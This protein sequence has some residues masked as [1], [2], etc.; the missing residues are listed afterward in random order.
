MDISASATADNNRRGCVRLGA[1]AVNEHVVLTDGTKRIDAQCVDLSAEGFGCICETKVPWNV[2]QRI[3]LKRDEAA[4][5]VRIAYV[6]DQDG[7]VRI[8]MQRVADVVTEA[9]LKYR[10]SPWRLIRRPFSFPGQSSL[11]VLGLCFT[12]LASAA[13]V[14][15]ILWPKTPTEGNREYGNRATSSSPRLTHQLARGPVSASDATSFASAQQAGGAQQ[16]Q[17]LV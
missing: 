13:V 15:L 1:R 17:Y 10:Y 5:E 9:D 3:V 7:Q 4:H 12:C 14:V 2:G 16:A 11:W 8:G 6:L